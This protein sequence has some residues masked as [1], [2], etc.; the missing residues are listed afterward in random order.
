MKKGKEILETKI[1]SNKRT[2][3]LLNGKERRLTG[4]LGE[5][6]RGN[7]NEKG[8]KRTQRVQK[9]LTKRG[10]R[11]EILCGRYYFSNPKVEKRKNEKGMK[12]ESWKTKTRSKMRD[13]H[14][15][16]GWDKC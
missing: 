14:D 10:A 6:G 4:R 2:I 15:N 11:G 7:C 12:K 9:G 16:I 5:K 8:R 3:R 1:R 13:L